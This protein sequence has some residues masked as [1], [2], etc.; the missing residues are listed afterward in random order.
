M[1]VAMRTIFI[2]AWVVF[3]QECRI[4]PDANLSPI[5][6]RSAS[7]L[8]EEDFW[9]LYHAQDVPVIITNATEDWPVRAWDLDRVVQECGEAPIKLHEKFLIYMEGLPRAARLEYNEDLKS[10]YNITLRQCYESLAQPRS[11][12][13]MVREI[14]EI[15]SNS[16]LY[17]PSFLSPAHYIWP[18]D[19]HDKTV[20]SMCQPLYR[21]LWYPRFIPRLPPAR[22]EIWDKFLHP[23]F[24]AAPANSRAYPAHRH[25][26]DEYSML[27]IL[28]GSKHFVHWDLDQAQ[29]L[30][31]LETESDTETGELL[32][33]ANPFQ[34]SLDAQPNLRQARG[35]EGVVRA[36]DLLFVPRGIH[37]V[38]NPEEVFAIAFVHQPDEK[39]PDWTHAW[40]LEHGQRGD[41]RAID[42]FKDV[43]CVKNPDAKVQARRESLI[44]AWGLGQLISDC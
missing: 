5:E 12:R 30:Y 11:M 22:N 9:S 26:Q 20:M 21:D 1:R 31:P 35:R 19:V 36:G 13:D 25:G 27:L 39:N 4:A 37:I 7:T 18:P 40:Q 29:Y 44:Q 23:R 28:E 10:A 41:K 24:F 43:A 16:G 34:P 8:S 15:S 14:R 33:M 17:S 38:H 3:A 2:C 6:R 42:F 32:Y